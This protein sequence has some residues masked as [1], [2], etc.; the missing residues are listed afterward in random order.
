[1]FKFIK[2]FFLA[3]IVCLSLS[4]TNTTPLVKKKVHKC[5]IHDSI[6]K[7]YIYTKLRMFR[8]N[9]LF[10]DI[11]GS[12]VQSGAF[13][14][15]GDYIRARI[16][17]HTQARIRAYN[18]LINNINI[19]KRIKNINRIK[20]YNYIITVNHGFNLTNLNVFKRLKQVILNL[21]RNTNIKEYT[22]NLKHYAFIIINKQTIKL[23]DFNTNKK[24]DLKLLRVKKINNCPISISEKD[25]NKYDSVK[26]FGFPHGRSFQNDPYSFAGLYNGK[27]NTYINHSFYNAH[28]YS[29][30]TYRGMSG[31][32]IIRDKKIIGIIFGKDLHLKSITYGIPLKK[33]KFFL[34]KSL[35]L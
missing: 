25:V 8:K 29:F 31:G 11:T 12:A 3:I 14:G 32:P 22:F 24:E 5:S 2:L 15:D 35:P 21:P 13:L 33:I 20:K 7:I 34:Q 18:K 6:V 27:T 23:I 26:G 9:K 10:Q 28:A 16:H 30:E 4:C 1:M 17:T 19:K